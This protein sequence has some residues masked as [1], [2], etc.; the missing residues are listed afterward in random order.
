MK[1]EKKA[2]IFIYV[3]FLVTISIVFA[4]ILLSNSSYL[5]NITS[6]Y[7]TS[8]LLLNNIKK[9]ADILINVHKLKNSDWNWFI[10]NISCPLNSITMSGNVNTD[11]IWSSLINSW[12]IIY[13]EWNYLWDSLKIYFNTWFTDLY[14]AEYKWSIVEI[15]WWLWLSN[16]LDS[17]NTNIDFS[18]YNYLIA[19]W[20]DDNMNSDNYMVTSTWNIY[21]DYNYEDNDV[22][23]RK[24]FH[25]FVSVDD[26][27]K[28]VFWN[29][30]KINDYINNNI[31][32]DDNLNVKIWNVNSWYLYFYVDKDFDI[33]LVKFNRNSYENLNELIVEQTFSWHLNSSEWYLQNNFWNLSLT[34]TITW[35]EYLFDFQNNDY[36]IFI[37]NVSTWSLIYEIKWETS[38]GSWIYI[39]PIDD[40][41]INVIKYLWNEILIDEDWRYISEKKELYFEK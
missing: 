5:F 28:K 18:S 16:F 15:A 13:C 20:I 27:Y 24:N 34:W 19:D 21:Y 12:W 14:Q 11:N 3:L 37:K 22:Y 35:N 39:T 30:S 26:W 10:D 23:A 8:F 41:D 40:S 29:T 31:N 33:K 2:V 32:N 38:S 6:Y 1:K 4:T 36:A 7:N 17:D 25:W 9:D